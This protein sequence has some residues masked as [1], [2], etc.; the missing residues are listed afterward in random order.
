MHSFLPVPPSSLQV[1]TE[2]GAAVIT[3]ERT[4][5]RT[6]AGLSQQP[7]GLVWNVTD[8][9]LVSGLVSS[10]NKFW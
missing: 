5:N 9:D 8:K 2:G 4:A 10:W 1:T 6:V 3:I 7:N